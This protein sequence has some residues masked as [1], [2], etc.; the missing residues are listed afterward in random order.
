MASIYY[1]KTTVEISDSLLAR[2]KRLAV[3]TGRPLRALIE[4]G[5][6][7]VLASE[8]TLRRYTLPDRSVGKAGGTNPLESLS[9]QDLRKEIY[10]EP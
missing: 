10:G 9:W 1:V 6:R 8:P 4:D 5:L 2:A 7:L 3:R